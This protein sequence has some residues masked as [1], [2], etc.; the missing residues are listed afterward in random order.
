MRICILL[1]GNMPIREA[2]QLS[3]VKAMRECMNDALEHAIM[4]DRKELAFELIDFS[5]ERNMT[6][7]FTEIAIRYMTT[8]K[9]YHVI[10]DLINIR[11]MLLIDYNKLDREAQM[12]VVAKELRRKDLNPALKTCHGHGHDH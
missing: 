11:A 1:D 12:G 7:S 8:K 3:Q 10:E 6:L 5:R 2:L 9:L 4:T